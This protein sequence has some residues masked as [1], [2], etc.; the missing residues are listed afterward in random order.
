[1]HR[2]INTCCLSKWPSFSKSRI[3]ACGLIGSYLVSK[4]IYISLLNEILWYYFFNFFIKTIFCNLLKKKEKK[5]NIILRSRRRLLKLDEGMLCFVKIRQF[6]LTLFLSW[7]LWAL[8]RVDVG[9]VWYDLQI[10]SF[11]SQPLNPPG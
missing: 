11:I 4:T 1:M 3:M 5:I 10:L 7:H 6:G 8:E 2:F 9:G